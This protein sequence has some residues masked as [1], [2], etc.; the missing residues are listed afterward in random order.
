MSVRPVLDYAYLYARIR[1]KKAKLLSAGD[2]ERL[3]KSTSLTELGR[4][5]S[6]EGLVGEELTQLLLGEENQLPPTRDVDKALSLQFQNDLKRLTSQ[7]PKYTLEFVN[8]FKEKV[9]LDN[10]KII[11]RGKHYGMTTE[12][13]QSF[14]VTHLEKEMEVLD[15]LASQPTVVQILENVPM[16]DY[17]RAL[18]DHLDVYDETNSPL[19]LEMALSK[20]YYEKLWKASQGLRTQDVEGVMALVGTEIDL[21]N[22]MT[23]MRAK[24]QGTTAE[25]IKQWLIPPA[26]K[27]LSQNV[28]NAMTD[29]PGL[30]QVNQLL[31][32]TQ[33]RELAQQASELFEGSEVTLDRFESLAKQF[34]VHRATQQFVRLPFQLGVLFAYLYLAEAQFQNIRAIVIG[35]VA[36]LKPELIREELIYF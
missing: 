18:Q 22:L 13:I 16:S 1:G 6:G 9:F 32:N 34:L 8:V 17:R 12:E 31:A 7:L 15:N 28:L 4:H 21:T 5:L 26:K 35:K 19:V 36:G 30:L 27:G 10:L 25:V 14:L 29:A 3:Y 2:Y 33:Y 23:V 24:H 20:N 11:I